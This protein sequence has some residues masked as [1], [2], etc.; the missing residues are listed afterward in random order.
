MFINVMFFFGSVFFVGIVDI[1]VG[2]LKKIDM[3][4]KNLY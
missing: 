3:L 2:E 4:F 1:M